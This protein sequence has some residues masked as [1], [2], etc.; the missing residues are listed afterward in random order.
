MNFKRDD[1][2]VELLFKEKNILEIHAKRKI[3]DLLRIYK[4]NGTPQSVNYNRWLRKK[5][6]AI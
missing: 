1:T 5:E 6:K 4:C 3:L 2:S